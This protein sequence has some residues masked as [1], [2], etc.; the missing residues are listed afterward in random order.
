MDSARHGGAR[1][2]DRK[3]SPADRRKL[4]KRPPRTHARV[5]L[6]T[7]SATDVE[8]RMKRPLARS[9]PFVSPTAITE[10]YA[11]AG[12]RTHGLGLRKIAFPRCGFAPRRSGSMIFREFRL[13]RHCCPKAV[14]HPFTVAGAV[15]E[16][17]SG[18]RTGFPFHSAPPLSRP[19][20]APRR[21]A[22]CSKR[23]GTSRRHAVLSQVWATPI[24]SSR[25]SKSS[26]VGNTTQPTGMSDAGIVRAAMPPTQTS[27]RPFSA[28][29]SSCSC[30][31]TGT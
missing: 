1:K 23:R 8:A 26:A 19:R 22:V 18:A 5:P 15:P 4:S 13:T 20:R 21:G 3:T 7:I 17:S 27:Q 10:G 28:A 29:A 14:H 2:A 31:S 6:L 12:L 25:C 11:E 9:A 30:F 16:W 24:R